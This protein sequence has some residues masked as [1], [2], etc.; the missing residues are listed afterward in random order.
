MSKYIKKNAKFFTISI[1]FSVLASVSAIVVQFAKGTVLDNAIAKNFSNT[2]KFGIGLLLLIALEILCR[3]LFDMFRGKY[4]TRTMR[5]VRDDYFHG[6]LKLEMINFF[7]KQ[8]GE[9]M[10]TYTNQ[11]S[12]IETAYFSTMPLIIDIVVKIFLITVSLFALDYKLALITIILLTTPLYVPK[13]VEKKLQAAEMKNAKQFEKHLSNFM[14]WIN[15]FEVIKNFKIENHIR[16]KFSVSNNMYMDANYNTRKLQ[17]TTQMISMVLS[18]GSHIIILLVAAFYVLKGKFSPGNFFVAVGMIDQLSYPIIA[19]SELVQN[20]VSSK[21]ICNKVFSII[22]ESNDRLNTMGLTGSSIDIEFDNVDFS[23]D[24]KHNVIND[25]SM[26]IKSKEKIMIRGASGSGKSTAI[27]LLLGYYNPDKGN[28]AINNIKPQYINNIFDFATVMRQ[29]PVIF[30]DTIY[31]NVALYSNLNG[32]K[33][34]NVLKKV[35]LNKFASEAGL[36]TLLESGG[37]N[38]S[39]GEKKRISLCRSLLRE[40]PLLILDEPLA[41]IDPKTCNDIEDILI[42]INDRT[43][44]VITHQFTHSKIDKFNKVHTI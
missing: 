37:K 39:G 14:D 22:N 25:L 19:L 18:Y 9:Y 16:E 3:Y 2:Y 43:L 32:D 5:D 34:I 10:A 33:V 24:K 17:Y 28:I 8:H 29:E 44:I 13:L 38:L 27:N 6:V 23:Y 21:P 12:T 15:G 26:N 30:E 41:N 36:E 35:G 7:S 1:I 20:L 40:T 31:N 4:L 42:N 11:L